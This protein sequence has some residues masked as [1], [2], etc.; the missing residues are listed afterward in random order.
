[1]DTFTIDL[2]TSKLIG[3]EYMNS[4]EWTNLVV[5][6]KG[7][8]KNQDEFM[9]FDISGMEVVVNFDIDVNAS[10]E[11]ESGDYYSAPSVDCEVNDFDVK[12]T[13][14][15][16]NEYIVDLDDDLLTEIKKMIKNS[17]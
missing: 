7:S 10:F 3:G 13:N 9:V 4:S 1:M 11:Y 16:I 2:N 12:I 15:T 14:L 6:N 5:E 17:L 8:F